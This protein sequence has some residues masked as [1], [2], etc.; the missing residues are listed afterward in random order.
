MLPEMELSNRTSVTRLG[1]PKYNGSGPR[2]L[3]LL[4]SKS[5][6]LMGSLGIVPLNWLEL[7]SITCALMNYIVDG[8]EPLILF[9]RIFRIFTVEAVI[10]NQS[11]TVSDMLVFEI[12]RCST[13]VSHLSHSGNPGPRKHDQSSMSVRLEGGTQ[14]GFIVRAM[15]LL[16]NHKISKLF[17][18][19]K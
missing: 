15:A 2:K 13:C 17:R 3:F 12:S 9:C 4:R 5:V 8:K 6:R 10:Q 11:R 19:D 1:A 18:P 7:R 16:D 14:V